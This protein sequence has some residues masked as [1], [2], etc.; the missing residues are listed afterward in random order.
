M[1]QIV[2]EHLDGATLA[3]LSELAKLNRLSIEEQAEKIL[4]EAVDML[5]RRRRRAESVDRIAAMTPKG[6]PQTDSVVL[7]REDRDR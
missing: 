5:A 7:L 2:L 1:T 6:V 4:A 3:A